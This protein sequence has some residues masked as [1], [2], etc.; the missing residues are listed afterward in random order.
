VMSNNTRRYHTHISRFSI[1][2]LRSDAQL[3]NHNTMR[4]PN[5]D[6]STYRGVHFVP[7]GPTQTHLI[8]EIKTPRNN[9]QKHQDAVDLVS[10]FFFFFAIISLGVPSHLLPLHGFH[11]GCGSGHGMDGRSR[12]ALSIWYC[13]CGEVMTCHRPLAIK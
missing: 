11:P 7:S 3:T 10:V 2:W 5:L 4:D 9:L 12:S 13:Q 1:A 6:P 8:S